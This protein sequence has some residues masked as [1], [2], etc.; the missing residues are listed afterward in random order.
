MKCTK[1]DEI[2]IVV[3][4]PRHVSHTNIRLED[5]I[6]REIAAERLAEIRHHEWGKNAEIRETEIAYCAHCGMK[7]TEDGDTY[8]GGCCDEDAKSAPPDPPEE[9]GNAPRS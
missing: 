5:F 3:P 6:V 2:E 4:V 1:I 7:W 9:G 8:N